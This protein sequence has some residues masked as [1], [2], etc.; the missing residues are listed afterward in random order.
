MVYFF[1]PIGKIIIQMRL[2]CHAT[3]EFVEY[4]MIQSYKEVKHG[5]DRP[6]R[7]VVPFIF[8]IYWYVV[9]YTVSILGISKV[10]KRENGYTNCLENSGF[11]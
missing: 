9:F 1:L 7:L 4:Q 8:N 3:I 10:D 2:V 5:I 6:R 11:W